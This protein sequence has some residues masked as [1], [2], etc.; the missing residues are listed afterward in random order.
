MD[1]SMQERSGCA[2]IVFFS[3]SLPSFTMNRGTLLSVCDRVSVR[4]LALS[5]AAVEAAPPEVEVSL[6]LH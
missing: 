1:F 4:T 5:I 2:A 3:S 6:R